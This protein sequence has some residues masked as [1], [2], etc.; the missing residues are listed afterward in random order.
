MVHRLFDLLFPTR[1]T[2]SRQ[3]PATRQTNSFHRPSQDIMKDQLKLVRT[4]KRET[5]YLCPYQ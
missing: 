3:H 1:F 2:R 5:H 4:E